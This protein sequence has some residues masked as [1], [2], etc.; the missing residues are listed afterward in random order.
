M[1]KHISI[2]AARALLKP[3]EPLLLACLQTAWRKWLAISSTF[4]LPEQ[5]TRTNTVWQY[6]V[7]EART[8]FANIKGIRFLETD[9]FMIAVENQVAIRFKHLSCGKRTAN[10]PT[11][12]ARSV[13]AQRDVLGIPSKAPVL[14]VG[15]EL[16]QLKTELADVIVLY[17]VNNLSEWEYSLL[18]GA[19]VVQ[20]PLLPKPA[21]PAAKASRIKAKPGVVVPIRKKKSNE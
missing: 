13:D 16:N 7:D 15:Y 8:L 11:K 17:A 20:L 5:R 19:T 4:V 14:T 2:D 12:R 1:T 10:Y 9:G 3:H 21:A 18:N 6:A